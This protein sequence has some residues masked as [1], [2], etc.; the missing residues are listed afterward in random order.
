MQRREAT[1]LLREM[2]GFPEIAPFTCIYLS[3]HGDKC[4][5]ENVELHVKTNN[6]SSTH[7]IINRIAKSHSFLTKD[8]PNGFL[9]IYTPERAPVEI[10]A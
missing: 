6:D 5:S 3:P 4:D 8:E 7:R 2:I 9:V 1:F 10:V